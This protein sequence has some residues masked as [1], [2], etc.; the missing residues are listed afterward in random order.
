MSKG[1][2]RRGSWPP[3]SE[4]H[5]A[6]DGG[7]PPRREERLLSVV[8]EEEGDDDVFRVEKE[9][10]DCVRCNAERQR[11]RDGANAGHR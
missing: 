6:G 1:V 3:A 4:I 11:N 10:E 7:W 8:S 9:E 2:L 5:F